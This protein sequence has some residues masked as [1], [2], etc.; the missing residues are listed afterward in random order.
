MG[1]RIKPMELI[2]GLVKL[3]KLKS[4]KISDWSDLAYPPPYPFL[5]CFLKHVK[6]QKKKKKK[7]PPK[8]ENLSWG[9][10]H[11]PTS[12]FFSEFLIFLTWWNP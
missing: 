2:R 12:E 10:T 5:I 9:L 6:Q 7:F 3:K 4:E 1:I 8:K 11:P